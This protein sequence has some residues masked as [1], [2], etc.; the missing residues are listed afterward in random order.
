MNVAYL[1]YITHQQF[2]GYPADVPAGLGAWKALM[3]T[4]DGQNV[5]GQMAIFFAVSSSLDN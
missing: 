2:D 3:A 5:L 4:S 1:K